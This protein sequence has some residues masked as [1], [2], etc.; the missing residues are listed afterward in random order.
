MSWKDWF[1]SWFTPGPHPSE[2]PTSIGPQIGIEHFQRQGFSIP[3]SAKL[4]ENLFKI[5]KDTSTASGLDLQNFPTNI[6]EGVPGS[7]SGADIM[8]LGYAKEQNLMDFVGKGAWDLGTS[9]ITIWTN[10]VNSRQEYLNTTDDVRRFYIVGTILDLMKEDVLNSNERGQIIR[11]TAKDKKIQKAIDELMDTVDMNNLLE[12]ITRDLIDLGEYSVRLEI[13]NGKGVVR[14]HDDVDPLNLVAFYEQ[15]IPTRYLQLKGREWKILPATAYAHFCIGTQKHRICL[16]NKLNR[17]W[18]DPGFDKIPQSVKDKLPDYVRIGTP[19]FLNLIEKIRELQVLEKL[20][21]ATKMNQITQTQL[22]GMRMPANTPP[23]EVIAAIKRYEQLLNVP[24]G[25]DP[26]TNQISLAEIMTVL[27]RLRVVPIFS[28]EK[29]G[30]DPLNVRASQP[31][32]DILN[33]TN[34]LRAII[35]SSI[36]IPPSL[37]FGSN[38]TDKVQEL[39][40]FSRYTRRLA[41]IQKALSKGLRQI[42]L[43]HLVNTGM[44]VTNKDFDIQFIQSL[45]DLSGLEKLEFDD[46]KQEICGRSLDFLAKAMSN[47][48]VAAAIDPVELIKWI[49]DKFSIL[50]DGAVFFKT[51]PATMKRV[52]A[53]LSLNQQVQTAQQVQSID[54]N[55]DPNR[56]DLDQFMSEPG[57]DKVEDDDEVQQ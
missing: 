2:Q 30:L 1:K 17:G 25:I 23:H 38:T 13:E 7:F 16:Q 9:L 35:M 5:R 22:V 43:A 52:M 57:D 3:E 10:A 39:R 27:G 29:G 45:V 12:D 37:I 40:M 42:V 41:S 15:G 49:Q 46:A 48:L 54:P 34:S 26:R 6:F 24:T 14:V 47:P 11:I 55:V 53:Q 4:V 50:A 51:D 8:K 36:G 32:D 21:P 44:T 20:M 28:D 31:I 56:K 18:T 19:M 33:A